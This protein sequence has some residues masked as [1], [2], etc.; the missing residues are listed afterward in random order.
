MHPFLV[1]KQSTSFGWDNGENVTFA[2][3]Q[4]TLCDPIW[5]VSSHG[6]RPGCKYPREPLYRVCLLTV[7]TF[8]V[9]TAATRSSFVTVWR[10]RRGFTLLACG[11][12]GDV[13]S[14][15]LLM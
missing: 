2:G 15:S 10:C 1:A 5:H 4:V 11:W 9:G 3:W 6:V 8:V 7:R 14:A 12:L 13:I